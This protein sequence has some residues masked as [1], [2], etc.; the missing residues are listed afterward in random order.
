[1]PNITTNGRRSRP[2]ATALR[3]QRQKRWVCHL[4]LGNTGALDGMKDNRS[5]LQEVQVTRTK[6]AEVQ[7][8][9][10]FVAYHHFHPAVLAAV[11]DNP[12]RKM[13]FTLDLTISKEY[14]RAKIPDL[15]TYFSAA[16]EYEG[17]YLTVPSYRISDAKADLKE[18]G[19]RIE[20][21]DGILEI[22]A[23]LSR[24]RDGWEEK[25][26][27]GTELQ[28]VRDDPASF[29][30]QHNDALLK[31]REVYRQ[32]EELKAALAEL[33]KEKDIARDQAEDPFAMFR[34]KHAGYNRYS[35]TSD[36]WHEQ[37][38]DSALQ[39]WGIGN[40]EQTKT[41]IWCVYE[42]EHQEPIHGTP[43]TDF[44]QSLLSLLWMEHNKE[45]KELATIFDTN[46][47]EVSFIVAE[48]SPL[49]GDVG[50]YLSILPFIDANF[51]LNT[52]PKS[53]KDLG[54]KQVGAIIDGKDFLTE[55]SRKHRVARLG[56]QSNKTSHSSFR[57]ITFRKGLNDD[58]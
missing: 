25:E 12:K 43:L 13:S 10:R 5:A 56:Q 35:I 42:L 55:T 15:S 9:R 11:S 50:R 32:K 40:W 21:N 24:R 44:E 52:E 39:L 34:S 41:F 58:Y 26:P 57:V 14:L 18:A 20:L 37:H 29:L 54:L 28:Q 17:D 6:S 51:L 33:R 19:R 2:N 45:Q 27:S 38:P 8:E 30:A 3:E 46:Q 36:K 7:R 53:Y 22:V 49:W 4:K 1:M 16:D 48:W 23:L 31:V 47:T